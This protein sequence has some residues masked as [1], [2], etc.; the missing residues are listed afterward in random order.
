MPK[1]LPLSTYPP[2][3]GIDKNNTYATV[4]RIMDQNMIL[5]TLPRS[6]RSSVT[7][8]RAFFRIA[9]LA[10]S[11]TLP[12]TSLVFA[13]ELFPFSPPTNQQRSVDQAPQVRPQLSKEVSSHSRNVRVR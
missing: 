4:L 10:G 3:E 13:A 12:I 11:C 7:A 6:P 8:L 2:K 1:Q 5:D 9:I